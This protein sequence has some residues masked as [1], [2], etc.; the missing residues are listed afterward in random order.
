MTHTSIVPIFTLE[1]NGEVDVVAVDPSRKCG[2]LG[3]NTISYKFLVTCRRKFDAD[4]FIIDHERIADYM[5]RTFGRVDV[6]PSCELIA[7]RA[8][9][10]VWTLLK[11]HGAEPIKMTVT[12]AAFGMAGV[13]AEFPAE[14]S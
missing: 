3:A 13:T 6:F 10:D 1:R 9:R 4:G 11:S 2:P 12:V 8:C 14:L 5:T 7:D